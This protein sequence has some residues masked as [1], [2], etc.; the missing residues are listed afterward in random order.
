MQRIG[1]LWTLTGR[2][3]SLEDELDSIEH[4]TLEDLRMLLD[5]FPVRAVMA[6]RLLPTG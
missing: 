2:H 5:A 4:V 3:R 1:R 6:G